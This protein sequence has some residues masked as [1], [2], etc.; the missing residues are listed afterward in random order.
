M[1][2]SIP[3]TADLDNNEVESQICKSWL[4][5]EVGQDAKKNNPGGYMNVY[6]HKK[7]HDQAIEQAAMKEAMQMAQQFISCVQQ[8]KTP[9]AFPN[10]EA[11]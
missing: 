5:S 9:P 3:I 2:S 4:I 8:N 1:L 11:A 10:T 6:S 7:E